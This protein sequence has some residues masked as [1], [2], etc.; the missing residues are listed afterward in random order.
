MSIKKA[1]ACV[2]IIMDIFSEILLRKFRPQRESFPLLVKNGLSWSVLLHGANFYSHLCKNLGKCF[3]PP[4]WKLCHFPWNY[5]FYRATNLGSIWSINKSSNRCTVR[6]L[7]C[8]RCYIQ[9]AYYGIFINNQ[10]KDS[11][12]SPLTSRYCRYTENIGPISPDC[13]SK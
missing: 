3:N 10:N 11:Q 13:M 9:S 8:E 6:I 7:A 4:N 12:G 5:I 1:Q 2:N